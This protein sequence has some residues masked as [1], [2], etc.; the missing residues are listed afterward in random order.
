MK[1]M[2]SGKYRKFWELVPFLC[3][4]FLSILR[5]VAVEPMTVDFRYAPPSWQTCIG[6]PDDWQK[7]LVNKEGALLYDYPGKISGFGIQIGTGVAEKSDWIKQTLVNPTTPVVR[8]IKKAGTIEIEEE[9]FA[10]APVY[11]TGSEKENTT[12][13]I[14]ACSLYAQETH[15]AS[16]TGEVDHAFSNV[17]IGWGK[18]IQF[19]IKAPVKQPCTIIFGLCEGWHDTGGKRILDLQIE[20]QT[21]KTVDMAG[22]Q[23]RNVPTL[24]AFDAKDLNEDGWIDLSVAANANSVDRNTILNVLWVFDGVKAPLRTDLIAGKSAT[25]PLLH[26]DCGSALLPMSNPRHDLMVVRYH[27][28]GQSLTEVHPEFHIQTDS[29]LL[30]DEK[31]QQINIGNQT[32]LT[33]DHIWS[34]TRR[35]SNNLTLQFNPVSLAGG[36][37]FTIVACVARGASTNKLPFQLTDYEHLRKRTVQFWQNAGLPYGHIEVPD[38]GIQALLD[39]SVRNIYQA[40]EIKNGLPVFQ[41]GPTCY[42]GL[43]VVD[44]SFLLEAVTFLGRSQEARNGI[45]YLLSQQREDGGI[46]LIDGHWKETGIALWAVTRHAR[47]TGDKTWLKDNWPKIEHAVSFIRQM[48][49]NASINPQAPNANLVPD[50]FSDGG[51]GESK[52]E[53]TNI[54]WTLAGLKAAIQAARW[55]DFHE[56]AA[57]WENEYND[58]L[59]IFQQAAKR[60]QRT[61]SFGNHY[62]PIRMN[63]DGKIAPQR[64]QWA[65]LHAVF[66]GKIFSSNDPL[67][68]GNMAMLESVEREGLVF[69][70]GWLAD[71]IWNYFGSF[72]AHAWLW[73]GQG[74]KAAQIL[75]GFA[76]HASPL[77][78][79]REEQMPAGLG[80]QFVGDMPH[81]WASAEFIRLVRHSLVLER[82]SEL[83]LFEGLPPVWIQPKA[84]IRLNNIVTEFGSMSLELKVRSDGKSAILHVTAPQRQP[85]GKI[86]LHLD[87]WSGDI[88]TVVLNGTG[89]IQKTILLKR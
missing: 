73:S 86:I 46:M 55:I 15:W 9:V 62:L 79:W 29:A 78:C 42:R 56:Q 45:K 47:L 82:D 3:F 69:G 24:Y 14:E 33:L 87:H 32:I 30:P 44:G 83:H 19:R 4:S 38:H 36:K 54:Y 49:H 21:R 20:G 40:R 1:T 75:Y 58:F 26:L 10:V 61:D 22:E 68:L 48:R 12:I 81:N 66:P 60:D 70:T 17:A 77:L 53:Y 43:W 16:P 71:G 35:G 18:P 31:A 27:N 63:D 23:G 65:F 13:A 25:R 5:S 37:D 50:G 85:P 74:L 8:T 67:V 41:V 89:F 88:G 76:N 11:K 57:D 6:L 34:Q 59:A 52:P 51:L 39:S 64:A 2:Q 7:T 84:V 72:Y 80:S 28:T